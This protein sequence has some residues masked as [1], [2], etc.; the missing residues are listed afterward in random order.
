M[1]IRIGSGVVR[2]A[3]VTL[4]VN[5]A[6]VAAYEGESLATALIASGTLTMSRDH[7]GRLRTPFCNMGVCFDCLVAVEDETAPGTPPVSVR[8]CMTAVRTG[9]RISVPVK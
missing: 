6:S 7:T 3:P 5:G 1:S 2:S 4:D 8:A 9:L